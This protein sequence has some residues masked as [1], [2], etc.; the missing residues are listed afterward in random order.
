MRLNYSINYIE[1]LA[2]HIKVTTD[3]MTQQ[4]ISHPENHPC[5]YEGDSVNGLEIYFESES[6]MQNFIEW[7]NEDDHKIVLRGNDSDDYVAEG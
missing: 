7:K 1:D 3:P 6:N 4:D 5:H 2:M